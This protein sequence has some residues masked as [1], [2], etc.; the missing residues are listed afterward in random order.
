MHFYKKIPVIST[1]LINDRMLRDHQVFYTHLKSMN[2]ITWT[3]HI[4]TKLSRVHVFISRWGSDIEKIYTVNN[5]CTKLRIIITIYLSS[6]FIISKN[7]YP[8]VDNVKN[9]M[10][11]CYGTIFLTLCSDCVFHTHFYW[12]VFFR[13]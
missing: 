8:E 4:M 5:T 2:V 3:S 7:A 11:F 12:L 1:W 13:K 9:M 6:S 10:S